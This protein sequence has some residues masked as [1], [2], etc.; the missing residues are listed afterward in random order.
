MRFSA[1]RHLR[2]KNTKYRER[3]WLKDYRE[4][5]LISHHSETHSGAVGWDPGAR[6][7]RPVET[8]NF[9]GV[10]SF[11][12]QLARLVFRLSPSAGQSAA[13]RR[14]ID[15]ELS[16]FADQNPCTVCYV[17]PDEE[18]SQ[19]FTA[20][21]VS[22]EYLDETRQVV[23]LLDFNEQEISRVIELLSQQSTAEI[24]CYRKKLTSTQKPSIQGYSFSFMKESKPLNLKEL[25]ET[26]LADSWAVEIDEKYYRDDELEKVKFR[27]FP[28]ERSRKEDP[29]GPFASVEEKTDFK[30]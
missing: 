30:Y 24:N 8:P 17:R 13:L 4:N 12:P 26:K 11:I 28:E 7:Q 15:L 22:A 16:T 21:T 10:R 20:P 25:P 23:D 19:G 18:F 5:T 2:P 1:V 27:Q 14:Y 6:P 29:F 9:N 3:T